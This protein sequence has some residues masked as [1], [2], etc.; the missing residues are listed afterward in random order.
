MLMPEYGGMM[1]VRDKLCRMPIY[2]YSE[3]K[4]RHEANIRSIFGNVTPFTQENNA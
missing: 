2:N 3:N 4:E 1:T